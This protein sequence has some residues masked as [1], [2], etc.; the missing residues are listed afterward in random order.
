MSISVEERLGSPAE[1]G[2]GSRVPIRVIDC[3]VHPVFRSAAEFCEYL[4]SRWHHLL[5]HRY[6]LGIRIDT[7]N[8]A[9]RVDAMPEAGPPGCDPD[10]LKRQLLDEA[11]IDIA[12][13]NHHNSGNVPDPAADAA[14][15][16]AINEWQAATWLGEYNWHGR[17]RA[18]IRVPA[19][20]PQAA[21]GE[22]ERWGDHPNFV[23][24]LAVHAYQPAFG[25]PMYEP[26]WRAAAERGLPVAVHA[27]NNQLG[28]I[29]SHITPYG[30]PSFFFEW[31]TAAYPA[32]YASH[33]ASLLCSGIFERI[34][35][36]RFVMVE[37]GVGWSLALGSHLDRNWRLLRS[38]V[39]D[40]KELPSHYLYRN[41]FFA[42]QPIEE[43][44]YGEAPVLQAWEELG[45]DRHI[46]FSTDYPHW[47][48]DHPQHAL[49]RLSAELK[50]RVL[51]EN[52]RELYHLPG[53]RPAD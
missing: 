5:R 4:P 51:F 1:V 29:S 42:T 33:A 32:V 31:H 44:F 34:P 53:D 49:P 2:T 40:V 11:G 3:D 36:L 17:Y 19:H 35:E 27:T 8:H 25:H 47:D 20:S 10:L 30:Q 37:G 28:T 14:C 46:L 21:I 50:R 45:A 18:A 48:F 52:A 22:I 9:L 15:C 24:V 43:P 23:Q 16:A 39:P 38:E 41:V 7:I 6:A 26:I 13:L 12:I